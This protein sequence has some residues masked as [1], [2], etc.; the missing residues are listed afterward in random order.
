ML[1]KESFA[2]V[3]TTANGKE[4]SMS[5]SVCFVLLCPY[6]YLCLTSYLD[7]LSSK[8]TWDS[9]YRK[10]EILLTAAIYQESSC[11]TPPSPDIQM[12]ECP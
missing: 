4:S 3:Q 5:M 9:T 7:T 10:Q 6:R 2:D 1:I 11:S 8:E 12:R